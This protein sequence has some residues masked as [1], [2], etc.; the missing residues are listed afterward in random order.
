MHWNIG[1]MEEA[2]LVVQEHDSWN[3]TSGL[4]GPKQDFLGVDHDE[5]KSVTDAALFACFKKCILKFHRQILRLSFLSKR[6]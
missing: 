5:K 6:K 4:V 1:C 2:L 3:R